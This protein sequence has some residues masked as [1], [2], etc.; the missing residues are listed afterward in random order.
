MIKNIL[1][2]FERKQNR[3]KRKK[4]KLKRSIR[5]NLNIFYYDNLYSILVQ[6]PLQGFDSLEYEVSSLLAMPL[7]QYRFTP[8][9]L[10]CEKS[11]LF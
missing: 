4:T 5:L 2:Q 10:G 6:R 7:S 8:I 1:K 11:R 9:Y 3:K